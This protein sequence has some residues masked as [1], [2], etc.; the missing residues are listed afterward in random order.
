VSKNKKNN[1]IG[2]EKEFRNF[3][4]NSSFESLFLLN[5]EN[6]NIKDLTDKEKENQNITYIG[7]NL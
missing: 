6:L 7:I 1:L 5:K 4:L 3:V 2:K